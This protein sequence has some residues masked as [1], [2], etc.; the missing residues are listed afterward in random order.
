[1]GWTKKQTVLRVYYT[2]SG[3]GDKY[4]VRRLQAMSREGNTTLAALQLLYVL[5]RDANT[6]KTAL[7]LRPHPFAND[8]AVLLYV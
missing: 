8:V 7:H 2:N 5:S 1:M 6:V 3:T 4:L